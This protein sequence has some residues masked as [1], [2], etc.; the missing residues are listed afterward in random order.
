MTEAPIG[1]LDSGIGGLTVA[2]A[3]RQKLPNECI[4][5]FGDTAHLPYGDKSAESIRQYTTSISKFL[6]QKGCKVVVIACN[7]ASSYA[8]KAAEEANPGI[9]I[10][11]VVSPAIAYAEKHLGEKS[12]GIIGT[13]GTIDSRIYPRRIKQVLPQA[14]VKSMATPLLASMV[15]EG[16]FNNNISAAVIN[17]YLSSH[18]LRGINALFLACTHYPLIKKEIENF[19]QSAK[20]PVSVYDNAELTA[21]AVKKYLD[22]KKL[23][24]PN[25][26]SLEDHFMVS[27]YTKSF[28]KAT[29]LFFGEQVKLEEVRI[30]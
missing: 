10:I 4:Y 25:P 2:N 15:E 17:A 11:D 5:Y 9:K 29:Q 27:D 13:K 21:S 26:A 22:E 18:H 23:S 19:Y 6:V 8:A 24:N 20:K 14:K 28:E 3:I 16:F 1:I 7:T 30:W 12:I